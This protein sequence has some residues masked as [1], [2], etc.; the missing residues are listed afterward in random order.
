[1]M[2][3]PY[4]YIEE[5]KNWNL[6]KLYKEK[7][8]LEQYIKNYKKEKYYFINSS[9]NVIA[10]VYEEYLIELNRLLAEKERENKTEKRYIELNKY[11]E[12]KSRIEK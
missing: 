5:K 3:D 10:S 11:N 8:Y 2:I 4:S 6:D 9:P 7:D 1:M 12:I